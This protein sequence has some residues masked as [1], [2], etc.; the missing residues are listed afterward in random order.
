MGKEPQVVIYNPMVNA[1]CQVPISFAKK[2]IEEVP[3]IKKNIEEAE[4]KPVKK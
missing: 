2:L 1:Y 4:A 3:K